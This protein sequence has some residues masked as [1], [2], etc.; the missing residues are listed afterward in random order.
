VE[1]LEE[2]EDSEAACAA[3]LYRLAGF[4]IFLDNFALAQEKL[5]SA[6]TE[7]YPAH[8]D[9][10]ENFPTFLLLEWVTKLIAKYSYLGGPSEII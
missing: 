10:L 3:I 5:E 4:Y 8:T 7:D 2:A 9:F 6:L 1:I